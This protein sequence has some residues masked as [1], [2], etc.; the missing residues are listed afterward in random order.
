MAATMS[1]MQY[2]ALSFTL[3]IAFLTMVLYII[4][5]CCCWI[6]QNFNDT[7]EYNSH[8]DESSEEA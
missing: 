1:T 7:A 6:E 5:K 4:W 8:N 3:M 2:V